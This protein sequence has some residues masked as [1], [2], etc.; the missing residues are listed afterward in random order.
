ME[1]GNSTK[2]V[3]GEVGTLGMIKIQTPA[4]QTLDHS[5]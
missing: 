4:L 2:E 1:F 5:L 3:K